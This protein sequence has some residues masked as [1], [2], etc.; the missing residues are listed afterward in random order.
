MPLLATPTR[1]S[2][3]GASRARHTGLQHNHKCPCCCGTTRR[4]NSWS[5]R[6]LL[7]RWAKR[8]PRGPT[9]HCY[10]RTLLHFKLASASWAA[11]CRAKRLP[12]VP[13]QHCYHRMLRHCNV[14]PAL[15][16]ALMPGKSL[17]KG[18]TQ[19]RKLRTTDHLERLQFMRMHVC[20][21][22][23]VCVCVCAF[24]C[25][26]VCVCVRVLL[27]LSLP[28]SVSRCLC[29]CG[30]VPACLRVPVW[31]CLSLKC[32][33][34]SRL[35][36]YC[37]DFQGGWI[38]SCKLD[39]IFR[40][41]FSS[42]QII[43]IYFSFGPLIYLSL[44]SLSVPLPLSILLTTS[45]ARR[46]IT[47]M[48]ICSSRS[49]TVNSRSLHVLTDLVGCK[50]WLHCVRSRNLTQQRLRLHYVYCVGV[51]T[52]HVPVAWWDCN[53]FSIALTHQ[54]TYL[55]VCPRGC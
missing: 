10:R 16:A 54:L 3:Q 12:R 48:G 26:C 55:P 39:V 35:S 4:H 50:D 28:L 13:T 22:V 27:S 17:P 29:G 6:G 2:A 44:W 14:T 51:D 21:G 19:T 38:G 7:L 49:S 45:S 15:W 37:D 23:C 36:L 9:Q 46:L 41:C 1:L 31:A 53:V 20:V 5:P 47:S 8:L 25:A 18:L 32:I 34:P 42:V 33:S 52:L 24:A 40:Y 11:F 30:S 43:V